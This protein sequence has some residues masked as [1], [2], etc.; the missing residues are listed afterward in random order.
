[1]CVSSRLRGLPVMGCVQV[2]VCLVSLA[3]LR[4]VT[5]MGE[6]ACVAWSEDGGHWGQG[7]RRNCLATTAQLSDDRPSPWARAFMSMPCMKTRRYA[8]RSSP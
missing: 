4:L 6:A 8:A 7:K 1:V 5:R 2:T 3:G